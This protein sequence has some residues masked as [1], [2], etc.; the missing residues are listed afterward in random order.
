MLCSLCA[1]ENRDGAK[2]CDTCGAAL[3]STVTRTGVDPELDAVR[4]AF[5]DR[6]AVE[7]LLGRALRAERDE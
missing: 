4:K 5:H 7:S 3:D 6:Y 2:F 1:R